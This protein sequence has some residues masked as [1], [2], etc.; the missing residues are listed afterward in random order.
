LRLRTASRVKSRAPRGRFWLERN[1]FLWLALQGDEAS[2][3]RV[4]FFVLAMLGIWVVAA[5]NYGMSMMA[6]EEMIPFTI[7]ILYVPL[8]IWIAAEASRRF[9]EDRSNH[10]FE[11]LLSTPLS[12]SQ[13]IQGQLQALARQFAGPIALVLAWEFSLMIF[14][15][16]HFRD[17]P[18]ARYYWPKMAI[19]AA[20]AAALACAGMWLGL[21]CKG[22][23]RAILASLILV[24]L[25]PWVATQMITIMLT[26]LMGPGWAFNNNGG[27]N[28]AERGKWQMMAALVPSLAMDLLVVAWVTWRLPQTFRQLAVRR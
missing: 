20:D 14:R 3:R 2:S 16:G 27:W 28:Q 22:R 25:V 23:I 19:L 12:V 5:L 17:V 24:L 8:K 21:K 1:P 18:A 4:W 6:D 26:V 13:I 11:S 15:P 9:S 10:T 7:F